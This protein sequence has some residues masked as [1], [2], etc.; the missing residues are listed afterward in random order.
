MKDRDD[1][2]EREP[3]HEVE[4]ENGTNGEDHKGEQRLNIQIS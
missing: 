1:E 4:G 3:E 2:A